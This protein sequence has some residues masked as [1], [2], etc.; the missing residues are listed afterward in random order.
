MACCVVNWTTSCPSLQVWA[1]RVRES[2]LF[3]IETLKQKKEIHCGSLEIQQR[4]QRAEGQQKNEKG[5]EG[6]KSRR[7][8]DYSQIHFQTC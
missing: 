2:L 7:E 3:Y 1:F 8:L 5:G 4:Q 6:G